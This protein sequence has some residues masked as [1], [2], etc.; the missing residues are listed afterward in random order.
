MQKKYREIEKIKYVSGTQA[1]IAVG[2]AVGDA[3]NGITTDTDAMAKFLFQM[4][5]S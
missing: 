3:V 1:I 2:A 4:G 5:Q